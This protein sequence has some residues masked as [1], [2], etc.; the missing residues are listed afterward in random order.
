MEEVCSNISLE[1]KSASDDLH[2]SL[3]ITPLTGL[4]GSCNHAYVYVDSDFDGFLD[5]D[6]EYLSKKGIT[7]V[8]II[9]TVTGEK[10]YSGR[11]DS[12]PMPEVNKDKREGWFILIG[13]LI[14]IGMGI[15]VKR[16][17][18]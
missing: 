6:I 15:L 1:Y 5:K 14:F 12:N 8:E 9:N 18:R 4:L 7:D 3:Y 10:I 2:P 13:V 16:C 11:L 17:I